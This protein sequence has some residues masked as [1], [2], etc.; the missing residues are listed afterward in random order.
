MRKIIVTAVTLGSLFVSPASIV[1][2]AT[3]IG[4]TCPTGQFGNLCLGSTDLGTTVGS[5]I[6]FVF[7]VAGLVALFFLVWGGLKWLTSGGDEKAVET[8][9][10]H[11]IAAIIGL[12]IIF[13][14]YL[15]VNVVLGFFTNGQASLTNLKLPS[16]QGTQ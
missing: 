2:A 10:A 16:L 1:E 15:I 9:R 4:K 14:S 13:L 5:L 3:S 7:V 6:S 12:V 11:I 8:A